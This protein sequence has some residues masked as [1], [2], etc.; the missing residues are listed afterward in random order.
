MQK[1][2]LGLGLLVM[3]LAPSL[4]SAQVSHPLTGAYVGLGDSVAAGTGALPATS[5]YVYQLYDHGVFG[6]T[7]ETGFSNLGLRAA[8]S[9][10]LRDH[11]VPQVLCAEAVQR[12]TVV[13]IT[14]GANDFFRGDFDVSAIARRVAESV[15]LLLNNQLLPSPVLDPVTGDACRALE[16]VTILVSN[17]Y[18]IP[19]PDSAT[20]VLLEQLL[21]GYDAALR[22]WLSTVVVPP[23]SR[24]ALVDLYTASLGRNGLVMLERHNG[25]TGGFDFDPHP[26]NLGHGFI[27]REFEQVWSAL[28]QVP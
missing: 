15:N 22:F 6:Q 2:T 19:H 13:T 16:G 7:Q 21:Q 1:V 5:G 4:A 23:G 20:F 8:R 11:Q 26:T 17:Y 10:D 9:W 14:T 18:S 3:A 28:Q 25:F 24:L 12:P 27:A